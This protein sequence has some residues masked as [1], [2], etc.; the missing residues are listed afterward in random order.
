[1]G[2]RVNTNTSALRAHTAL[3][4]TTRETE[5]SAAKMAAGTRITKAADDA[6]G[7]AISEKMKAHI[8]SGHQANRNANDGISLVQVAEGG[9]NESTSILTRMRELSVQAASDTV[10]DDERAMSSMEYEGLKRELDRIAGS[11]SYNGTKLLD[12]S[13]PR[14]SFQVG[15]G[16]NTQ[17]DEIGFE[18]S[19]FNAGTT[20]LGVSGES[21]LRKQEA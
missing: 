3:S 18:S 15:T 20:N 14:I 10:G 5:E 7:L 1:M 11:V 17:E 12:G 6:A 19:R 2:F 13:G 8:R 4:K 21:I 16:A 9:L